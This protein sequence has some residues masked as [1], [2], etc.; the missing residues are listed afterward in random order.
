MKKPNI[1]ESEID[2]VGHILH[3][4]VHTISRRLG[5]Y[6]RYVETFTPLAIQFNK[7][8]LGP[9]TNERVESIK[10]GNFNKILDKYQKLA[11]ADIENVGF[12]FRPVGNEAISKGRASIVGFLGTLNLHHRNNQDTSDCPIVDGLPVITEEFKNAIEEA[13]TNRILTKEG[14]DFYKAYMVAKEAVKRLIEL[15]GNPE[16]HFNFDYSDGL[17]LTA[18]PEDK[19]FNVHQVK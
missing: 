11:E 5:Q 16:H 9:L 15:G 3:K 18:I 14:S 12:V 4:N 17:N 6:Q 1:E 2:Y 10:I 13:F 19:P 8:G 7:I